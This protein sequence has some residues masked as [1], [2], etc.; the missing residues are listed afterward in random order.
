MEKYVQSVKS[1]DFIQCHLFQ[2]M[3]IGSRQKANR[4]KS[5]IEMRTTL[6]MHTIYEFHLSLSVLSFE[7][8]SIFFVITFLL[9]GLRS[10]VTLISHVTLFINVVHIFCRDCSIKNHKIPQVAVE[11]TLI[12]IVPFESDVKH[13]VA[14]RVRIQIA[15]W[16]LNWLFPFFKSLFLASGIQWFWF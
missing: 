10:I 13:W 5:K 7:S 3:I 4:D 16:S 6:N 1:S 15:G 2:N 12:H 11:S 14:S 9:F 8:S